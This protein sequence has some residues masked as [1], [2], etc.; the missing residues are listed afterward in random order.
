MGAAVGQF[1]VGTVAEACVAARAS[2]CHTGLFE[3]EDDELQAAG[4][5][6]FGDRVRARGACAKLA[7]PARFAR[8]KQVRAF[9]GPAPKASETGD[10]DRKG[11][12]LSKAGPLLLR[13]TFVLAADIAREQDPKL[14]RIYYIQMVERAKNH[15][16]ALCVVAATRR[17]RMDR[18]E[19]PNALRHPRHQR[20]PRRTDEAAAIIAEHWT[21]PADVRARRRNR[22]SREGPPSD[23]NKNATTRRPSANS[24][25]DPAPP[26]RQATRTTNRLTIDR[27]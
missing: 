12:V 24:I 14:A 25:V 23:L 10:T 5:D 15:L 4:R 7:D 18:H 8:A 19:T 20:H 17:T 22:K 6:R 2:R 16:G 3:G 27:G 13:T 9:T 11:Q 26:T 21:V 1:I